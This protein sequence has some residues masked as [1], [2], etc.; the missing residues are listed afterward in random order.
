VVHGVARVGQISR[1][2]RGANGR[3]DELDRGRHRLRPEGIDSRRVLN[4]GS[5][6]EEAVLLDQV[7]SD[8]GE[9]KTLT[10]TLKDLAEANPKTVQPCADAPHIPCCM[11]TFTMRA[12]EYTKW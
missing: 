9:A 12:R 10:V 8:L 2:D 1:P 3:L 7:A 5:I 6:G 4:P 11:L